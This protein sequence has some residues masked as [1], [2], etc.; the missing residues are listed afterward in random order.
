MK[1]SFLDKILFEN[2]ILQL[3]STVCFM[4]FI[5]KLCRKLI[6]HF[7][8]YIKTVYNLVANEIDIGTNI[9]HNY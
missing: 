9:G 1:T 8:Y 5:E 7:F 6:F 3:F 2:H 4:I